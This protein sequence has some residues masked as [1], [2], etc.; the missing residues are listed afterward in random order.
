M[1]NGGAESALLSPRCG[2]NIPLVS[3]HAY[4]PFSTSAWE[5]AHKI[6]WRIYQ[7]ISVSAGCND[8]NATCT[9]QCRTGSY[10]AAISAPIS[11]GGGGT[12]GC[13]ALVAD[14]RRH[15]SLTK[16][17]QWRRVRAP[18]CNM[19][20]YLR[21]KREMNAGTRS[22]CIED[23][24]KARSNFLTSLPR[25]CRHESRQSREAVDAER[26]RS[27]RPRLARQVRAVAC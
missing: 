22:F 15:P 4:Q 13:I 11:F 19:S 27:A 26:R 17:A 16:R 2:S 23:N 3:H 6:R 10:D 8:L 20:A 21:L 9:A 25:Q 1:V 12:G 7:T 14:H 24:C 18:R 5:G